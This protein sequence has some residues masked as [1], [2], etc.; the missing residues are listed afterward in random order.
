[1]PT[2][3][4]LRWVLFDLNGTLV[5]TAVMAQPLGDSG[6]DEELVAAAV[7]DAVQLA[8]V[9]TL[10]RREAAFRDLVRAGLR[11]RLRLAG[12]QESLADDAVA[13]MG[14]MPAFLDAPAA[15]EHLRGIG[16]RLGVL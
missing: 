12:R 6:A 10:T 13:L 9:V 8:M 2:P 5:D 16:L 15:L 4:P 1:M 14:S 11:R 7:D 3:T